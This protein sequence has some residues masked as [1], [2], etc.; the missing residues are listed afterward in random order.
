MK[1]LECYSGIVRSW[2]DVRQKKKVR[3]RHSRLASDREPGNEAVPSILKG[4]SL[5]KY[6]ISAGQTKTHSIL[7]TTNCS[8]PSSKSSQFTPMPPGC[9]TGD[10]GFLLTGSKSELS[11]LPNLVHCVC[12]CHTI[13]NVETSIYLMQNNPQIVCLR[14]RD[15]DELERSW[16]FVV[17]QL[18]VTRPIRYKASSPSVNI[19]ILLLS[20]RE[21][22]RTCHLG[23]LT[24]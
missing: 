2:D 11:I 23:P 3:L 24:S 17:V 12:L 8:T 9:S 21:K 22:L 18:I 20:F 16:S 10:S 19:S 4:C 15:H 5:H 1:Y 7:L 6:F 14:I 13:L